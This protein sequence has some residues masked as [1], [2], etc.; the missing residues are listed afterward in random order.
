MRPVTPFMITPRRCCAISPPF[1][2]KPLAAGVPCADG[3]AERK[4]SFHAEQ[5]VDAS[6]IFSECLM[7]LQVE[8][9]GV[10][11]LNLKI[12]RYAGGPGGEHDDARTEKDRLADAV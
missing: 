7:R 1:E 4:L 9:A 12:V 10:R 6:R 11:Q 5:P 8:R 2:S 3:G